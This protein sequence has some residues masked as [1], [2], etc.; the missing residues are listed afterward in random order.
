MEQFTIYYGTPEGKNKKI[1]VDSSYP[2]RLKQQKILDGQVLEVHTCVYEVSDRE[3]AL[4]RQ[5]GVKVDDIPYHVVYF[6]NKDANR[7]ENI[8]RTNSVAMQGNTNGAGNKGRFNTKEIKLKISRVKCT[9]TPEFNA[10]I[11]QDSLLGM[12][13]RKLATKHNTSF[14]IVRRII[15][16]MNE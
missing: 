16:H 9:T 5:Y 15:K 7:R 12:S 13:L 11:I 8:S 3:Q 4:Q 1:G 10:L 14:G 2:N 6:K